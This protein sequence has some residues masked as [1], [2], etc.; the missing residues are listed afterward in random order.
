MD[1]QHESILISELGI[2]KPVRVIIPTNALKVN[3]ISN[4]DRKW[5]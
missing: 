1:S 5:K 4:K 3:S 2:T